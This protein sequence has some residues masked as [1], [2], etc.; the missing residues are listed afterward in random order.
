ME[1]TDKSVELSS[2]DVLETTNKMLESLSMELDGC[3]FDLFGDFTHF[4]KRMKAFSKNR[5]N[6]RGLLK[7]LGYL[8]YFLGTTEKQLKRIQESVLQL[9]GEI[10]HA[11]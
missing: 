2:V 6:R 5:K 1:E 11:T 8:H 9:R 10:Q 3:A 7:N 4:S